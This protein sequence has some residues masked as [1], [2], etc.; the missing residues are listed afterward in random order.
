MAPEEQEFII[1]L[2]DVFDGTENARE[3]EKCGTEIA[4]KIDRSFVQICN[5][6]SL[7]RRH[8]TVLVG[9]YG[10]LIGENEETPGVLGPEVLGFLTGRERAGRVALFFA[11]HGQHVV[12]QG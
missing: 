7:V 4:L 11:D 9:S 1:S 12:P 2:A 8:V 3:I 6:A 5:R 10:F